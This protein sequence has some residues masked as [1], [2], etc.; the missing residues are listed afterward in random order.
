MIIN[1]EDN[2]EAYLYA[3]CFPHVAEALKEIGDSRRIYGKY[4]IPVSTAANI[5]PIEFCGNT[6]AF[7]VWTG[8]S[9]NVIK[10]G[11]SPEEYYFFVLSEIHQTEHLAYISYMTE[12]P[13]VD[14]PGRFE[15]FHGFVDILEWIDADYD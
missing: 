5:T 11:A 3:M 2:E 7:V 14:A 6:Y 1:L 13:K 12:L 10:A 9:I 15:V 8:E 4:L